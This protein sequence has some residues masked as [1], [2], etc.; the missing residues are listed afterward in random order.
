MINMLK[1]L[2]NDGEHNWLYEVSNT[3]LQRVCG[4]LNEAYQDFFKKRTGFP[5]FKSKKRSKPSFPIDAVKLWFD[6]DGFAHIIKLGKV[7][8]RTDFTLP[9]G[10]GQK[11]SNPRVSNINGKWMLSFGVECEN[12]I[13][14]LNDYSVGIDLGIKDSAVVAYSDKKLVFSNINKSR[15]V[16]LL[17]QKNKTHSVFYLSEVR[18]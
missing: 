14:E 7:K 15:Q 12:Q 11:F 6:E 2:K 3:S 17:K 10:T 18:S 4:D 5:K 13:F 1:P 9:I 16:R 8:F